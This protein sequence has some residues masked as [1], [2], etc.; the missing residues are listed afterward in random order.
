MS[1]I[2]I[3]IYIYIYDISSLRDKDHCTSPLRWWNA[4][5]V[6]KDNAW[7]A[8]LPRGSQ[9]PKACDHGCILVLYEGSGVFSP[10]TTNITEMEL[11]IT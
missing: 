2:Y 9:A 6:G 8:L 4:R 3:Y 7:S 11:R 10:R 5:R 1:Y